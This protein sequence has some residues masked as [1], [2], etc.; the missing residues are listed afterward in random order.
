L[1]DDYYQTTGQSGNY[2]LRLHLNETI[3]TRLQQMAAGMELD[4][5]D[6]TTAMYMFLLREI[7]G[8]NQV[9][10]E[11]SLNDDPTQVVPLLVDMSEIADLTVLF[12][13][14]HEK[15]ARAK[16]MIHE[17][18]STRLRKHLVS[19]QVLPLFTT[20][21]SASRKENDLVMVQ[22]RDENGISWICEYNGTILCGE[23]VEE[24]VDNYGTLLEMLVQEYPS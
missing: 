13:L 20:H 22:Q 17:R 19:P 16:E 3:C 8:Q 1:P 4:L 9:V 14:V 15:Y 7:S 18:L 23:K 6:L 12:R 10:I 24:L 5:N 2:N 21:L 11:V